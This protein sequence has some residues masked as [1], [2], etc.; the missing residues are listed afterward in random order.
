MLRGVNILVKLS[1]ESEVH[2]NVYMYMSHVCLYA[3]A[4]ARAHLADKTV[5]QNRQIFSPV[6]RNCDPAHGNLYHKKSAAYHS[7]S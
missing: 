1:K 4:C 7:F 5:I 3:G 2:I 6:V